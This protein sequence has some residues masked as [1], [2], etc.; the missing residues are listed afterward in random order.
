MTTNDTQNKQTDELATD[1]CRKMEQLEGDRSIWE[2]HWQQI[3]ELI[4]PTM[5]DAFFGGFQQQGEKRTEKLFDA[6]AAL[7]LDRFSSVMVSMLTPTSQ[8]WH[9]LEATDDA[10]MRDLEVANWFDQATGILFRRRYNAKSAFASAMWSTFKQEGAFGSGAL[11][12]SEINGTM[13]Y[14]SI[15]LSDIFVTQGHE[16]TLHSVYRRITLTA[17]QALEKFGS[18]ALP[19][20]I[21]KALEKTPQQQFKF[22]HCVRPQEH[23]GK[24]FH[25]VYVCKDAMCVVQE[26]GFYTMP[27]QFGRYTHGPNEI[28]G[29][30]PAM[31]VLP[32][33]KMINEMSKSVIRAAHK[34]ID[35]PML[36]HDDGILGGGTTSVDLTP[37]AVNYGGVNQDGRQLIQ[38]L[39]SGV[40]VDIGQDMIESRQG[41][42]NDAFLVTL[43][44]ILVETPEMTATE[45]M[46]R[47]QEKGALLA[48]TM[49]RQQTELL[50][51]LI[52]REIDLAQRGGHLPDM[53]G[54]LKE[55]KGEYEIRYTSPLTRMQD[56]EELVGI[57]RTMEVVTPIAQFDPTILK[58]IDYQRILEI[59]RRVT[60][61]PAAIIRNEEEVQEEM[62]AE[63][64][65]QQ[66]QQLAG[67][68]PGAASATKDLAQAQA[69]LAKEGIG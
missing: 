67:A 53:P 28:Y 46:I 55:A 24:A 62:D 60:G 49:E 7:A 13:R 56:A 30:S 59:T 34:A 44:Q 40:R 9:K 19:E 54:A 31:L 21:L 17:L 33:L 45:A 4:W 47:A 48:P 58:R 37:A 52:E 69:V 12:T 14:K 10:L 20:K 2:D 66:L 11:F 50:A 6:T 39:Q 26:G 15:H 41:V 27:Y 32:E 36:V 1:I 22:I 65:E 57:Q 68:V 25:S 8:R 42:V 5:S 18:E 16:D 23:E 61:A 51:P 29:R 64:E 63:K 35:P 38:P 3:A 43:F